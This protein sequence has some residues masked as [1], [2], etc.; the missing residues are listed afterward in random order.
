MKHGRPYP[1]WKFVLLHDVWPMFWP[2]SPWRR[3]AYEKRGRHQKTFQQLLDELQREAYR[4]LFALTPEIVPLWDS[5]GAREVE[6][7]VRDLNTRAREDLVFESWTV[8]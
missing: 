7:R 3:R 1:R 8:L 5:P 6:Q 4:R 2:T